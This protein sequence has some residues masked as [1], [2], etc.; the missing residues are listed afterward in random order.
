MAIK[1]TVE[2]DDLIVGRKDKMA[3]DKHDFLNMVHEI[4]H[5]VFELESNE[6]VVIRTKLP[7]PTPVGERAATEGM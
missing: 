7:P 2:F 5:S 3:F 4:M 6:E 1:I